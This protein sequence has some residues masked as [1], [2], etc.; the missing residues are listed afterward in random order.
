MVS[1]GLPCRPV[2]ARSNLGL[3]P[4]DR[5]GASG[6]S[7]ASSCAPMTSGLCCWATG[8]SN[9]ST[10]PRSCGGPRTRRNAAIDSETPAG[11]TCRTNQ[12][13]RDAVADALRP[14]EL[15]FLA[16]ADDAMAVSCTQTRSMKRINPLARSWLR[17]LHLVQF[18]QLGF[19]NVVLGR[20]MIADAMSIKPHSAM[21]P[22][23][24]ATQ[25]G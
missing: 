11:A 3:E 2:T 15:A 8:S 24:A 13:V 12:G 25:A 9:S 10:L 5:E 16:Q 7:A 4:P 1:P 19:V 23:A 6:P 14:G 20:S 22:P 21:K 18:P 17:R